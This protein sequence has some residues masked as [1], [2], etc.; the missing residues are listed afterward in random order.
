MK[1]LLLIL[2]A[3]TFSIILKAEI[4]PPVV[5][6]VDYNQEPLG[7]DNPKPGFSWE[8]GDKS[9]GAVQS[10]Y[11]IIVSSSPENL[12]KN[13]GDVWDTEK[14]T[15]DQTIQVLYQGK[16]LNSSTRYYWK[17][18]TWD[19]NDVPSKFSRSTWFETGILNQNEWKAEW[20]ANPGPLPNRDEDYYERMPAP[21]FRK[22]FSA[23]KEIAQARLYISGLG[24]YEAYL[25]GKK[26]GDHRLDPGWTQ[27]AKT[28]YYAAYDVTEQVIDGENTLGVMLGHGWYTPSALRVFGRIDLREVLTTGK[29]K[30]IAQLKLEYTDGSV[31]WINTDRSWKTADGPVV[32]N[33][34]YLGEWY[35]AR[36]EQEGWSTAGFDDGGWKKVEKAET[37]GGKLKWQFIP[38][39]KH[40][41]TIYP[42][43]MNEPEPG[44]YVID[45]GQNFA[46]VIR[47]KA[48]AP[49]GTEIQF[50]FAELLYDD[51]TLDF[52]T[53]AAT[54]IKEGGIS[55]G[56]GAPPTA[57]QED[58]YIC[59]GEPGEIFE[60][61]FTFHGF[62][63]VEITGLPYKPG[64]NDL[65][66]IRM[67]ADLPDNASFECSNDLFN[68][69]QEV[70]EWTMLSNVFSVESDCPAREKFGYG[71]D[72]VTAGETYL[73]NYD[74]ATFYTKAVRDFERDA[75][76][77]GGMTECAPNIGI[78]AR[79]VTPDTGPPGWTLAHPFLLEQLY[80]Y[81]GNLELVKEQYQPLKDL[82]DFYLEHVDGLIIED[83]IGDHVSV[84]ERPRPVTSTAF[85]YHHARILRDMAKLLDK[86][87]DVQKYGQLAEQIKEGFIEEFVNQETGEVYT[88]T[89]AAQ[90]FALYYGLLPEDL[91]DK[92]VEVLKNEIFVKHRGHLSTGIFSTKM[93]LNYL[94]DQGLD[95]WNYTM[96]NQKEYPGFGYMIDNGATTL[97]ENWAFKKNDSKNHP[98]FGSISEWFHKSLLGIQQKEN[99]VAFK[100]IIIKPSLVGG[101]TYA[102]GHY[103]SVRGRISS[104]WW[105]FG[106]DIFMEVEI[107]ANTT[108][109]VYLPFYDK[110]EPEVFEG[111]QLL[112]QSGKPQQLPEEIQFTRSEAGN[113][114]FRVGAGR[115]R[116]RVRH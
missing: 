38:P 28:V 48:N 68:R 26:V 50:R 22:D 9:R 69:V 71:G 104:H 37:P 13:Q 66:G 85:Y 45:L 25:N 32:R 39:I 80:K 73:Y 36:M 58:G 24:Y 90:V 21:I 92:A 55:G 51:G 91:K 87:E 97:W 110:S 107:P 64:L 116:F 84:D 109:E 79:G 6:K 60:P 75:R 40:T 77:N 76:A 111:D 17:V 115:Y 83:G 20:I 62:R 42:V 52:R 8:V 18:Q 29:P 15:S 100:E 12:N 4:D 54:Q 114:V 53:T 16:S 102:K 98:M 59:K 105:K 108:A 99:S 72:M 70:A 35:D 33:N 81:Y 46:G 49:A 94:S 19:G 65:V 14:V 7:M 89:Q 57:W 78:N 47:F 113:Y 106:D 34:V 67:N 63:Y 86:S 11:R 10:A 103:Q 44:M 43:S 1:Q 31:K 93:M 5:L 101:L 2:L 61:R 27:Y 23:E 30:V 41:R 74:M 112:L 96:M 3:L 95:E 88:R 82:V 56:P